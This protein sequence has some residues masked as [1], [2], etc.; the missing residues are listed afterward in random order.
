MNKQPVEDLSLS[1]A[2]E[3]LEH[4]RK[5]L[6]EGGYLEALP[7]YAAMIDTIMAQR[8]VMSADQAQH[9]APALRSLSATAG[10]IAAIF[11]AWTRLMLRLSAMDVVSE[12]VLAEIARDQLTQRGASPP[13]LQLEAGEL[14]L[15]RWL[16]AHPG[17]QPVPR[18]AAAV[19]PPEGVEPALNRL[20]S[21]GL[22]R[23]NPSGHRQRWE[24]I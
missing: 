15:L 18:I 3:A 9:L 4:L 6:I 13:D 1:A 23:A 10:D 8:L 24:C 12:S 22:V 14:E 2:F 17:P 16:Q 21:L 11:E 7:T 5:G 20:Y 19:S